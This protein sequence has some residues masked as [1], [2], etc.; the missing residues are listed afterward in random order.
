MK[1]HSSLHHNERRKDEAIKGNYEKRTNPKEESA[2]LRLKS[3]ALAFF[4]YTQTFKRVRTITQTTTD[5]GI[6]FQRLP[7]PLLVELILGS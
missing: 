1:H 6:N 4:T 3:R 5:R 2:S 7:R